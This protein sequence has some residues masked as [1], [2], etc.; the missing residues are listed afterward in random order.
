MAFMGT[1]TVRFA[2]PVP[3]GEALVGQAR[4][5]GRERR[6][7]FISAAIRSSASGSELA[8]ATAVL[9]IA[10]VAHLEVDSPAPD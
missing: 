1:L 7:V 4:V 8:T 9:I 10:D 5:D 6:K 3:V 2:M